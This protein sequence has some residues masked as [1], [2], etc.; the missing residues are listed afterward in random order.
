MALYLQGSHLLLFIVLLIF[1]FLHLNLLPKVMIEIALLKRGKTLFNV[2]VFHA[3]FQ[4]SERIQ[5]C[6]IY[7]FVN[8]MDIYNFF[9]KRTKN[10]HGII[11]Q[12]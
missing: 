9:P 3:D 12:N 4:V 5:G 11:M 8:F 1:T 2:H 7:S 10:N 6:P